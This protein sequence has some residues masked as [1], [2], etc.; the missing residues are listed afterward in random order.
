[1]NRLKKYLAAFVAAAMLCAVGCTS[2]EGVSG[3]DIISDS[4]STSTS[5][6]FSDTSEDTGLTSSESTSDA[7]HDES[8]SN[9]PTES[10]TPAESTTPTASTSDGATES[11]NTTTQQQ[12]QTKPAEST[13][14]VTYS[15]S[16]SWEES[17]AICTQLDFIVNNNSS[18]PMS[19]WK[20]TIDFGQ[21]VEIMQNWN[22]SVSPNGNNSIS[23]SN[24]EYNGELP[25]GSETAFGIIVKTP[26]SVNNISVTAGGADV[27][28][29]SNTKPSQPQQTTTTATT[30]APSQP[31]IGEVEVTNKA[32]LVSE[33]GQLSVKGTDLVDK[34]GSPIQLRGVSTHGIQW[35]PQFANKQAFKHLRDEWNINV[36]RLAMYTGA[37]EGYTDSTKAGIEQT[38][39]DAV[40]A[41]IELDMYVIVDWHI[42]QD[43]SPQVR[44][45]DSLRFFEYMS[46][47]YADY[48]NIIYEICNEPNGYATWGGDIKPYAKEVI[49]VIR[50]N[51]PDSVIIVGT[52][53]WSQ[54]IDKALADPLSYDNVMYA[55]H[56]YAATHTD[57][58]RDRLKKC[59]NSG[60]PI[61]VSEFGNCDASGN[62]SNNFKEA[63]KWL[64]LLDSLNI[65]YMNW[66]LCDKNEAASILRPGA[67]ST[68]GW[69][70]SNLTENGKFMKQWFKNKA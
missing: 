60:L 34:N 14:V 67:S 65:S 68:G 31:E 6:I 18:K 38:V 20:L 50:R 43:Q 28:T 11:N 49:P 17:G 15:S 66:S 64:D 54:D 19:S 58:L 8:E 42:L 56:Y 59:Y 16:N 48:P 35:F 26:A 41:C 10:T 69:S 45:A 52:P 3:T 53:T 61:I 57:W 21:T 22:S 24:V 70:D 46:A 23:V 51:D 9:T 55:L 36:I 1:M 7:S 40:D 12:A 63:E 2:T 13:L 33:H 5:S 37:G 25:S 4:T 30:I 39:Q 29:S 27:G 44:K 62:G 47:K 32:G